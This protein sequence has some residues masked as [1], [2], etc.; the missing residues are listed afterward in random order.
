VLKTVGLRA[1]HVAFSFTKRRIQSLMRRVHLEYEY[2]RANDRSKLKAEEISDKLIVTR[3][4]KIFKDMSTY[5][6]CPVQEYNA[7]HPPKPVSSRG[8][9]L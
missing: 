5:T 7:S 9:S 4:H 1:E 3:L 6:P 2:T 8:H